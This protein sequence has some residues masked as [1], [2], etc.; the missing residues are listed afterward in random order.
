MAR[1]LRLKAVFQ[2]LAVRQAES[3][4]VWRIGNFQIET[5]AGN[6]NINRIGMEKKKWRIWHSWKSKLYL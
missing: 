6:I 4:R 5:T 3:A 1:S 2:D